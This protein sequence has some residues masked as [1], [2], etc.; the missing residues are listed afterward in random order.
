MTEAQNLSP[1]SLKKGTRNCASLQY[2]YKSFKSIKNNISAQYMVALS[3]LIKFYHLNHS[4][5]DIHFIHPAEESASVHM[6]NNDVAQQ[7]RTRR[8]PSN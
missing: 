1:L 6:T 5:D 7:F 2:L 8:E 3:H 4:K